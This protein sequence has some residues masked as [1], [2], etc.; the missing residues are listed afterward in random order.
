MTKTMADCGAAALRSAARLAAVACAMVTAAAVS[1][2]DV[3]ATVDAP[4]PVNGQALE[5]PDSRAGFLVYF[6]P[7]RIWIDPE[8]FWY[9]WA[10]AQRAFLWNGGAELPAGADVEDG[11]MFIIE[12]DDG[13]CLLVRRAGRWQQ[14]GDVWG[15]SKRLR[16][17]GGCA[18]LILPD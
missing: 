15:W 17:H 8:V 11:N 6:E 2:Q 5:A 3:A 13:P 10:D 4:P 12:T 1:A 16:D 14:A 18:T 7:M 9:R